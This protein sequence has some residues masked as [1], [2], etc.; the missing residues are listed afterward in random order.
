MTQ[1]TFLNFLHDFFHLAVVDE[2]VHWAFAHV[3]PPGLRQVILPDPAQLAGMTFLPILCVF[4]LMLFFD[5]CF[6]C[7]LHVYSGGQT[8]SYRCFYEFAL[9]FHLFGIVE[10]RHWRR[11]GQLVFQTNQHLL[12]ILF[13]FK[14]L[15]LHFL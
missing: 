7:L 8:G 5:L 9:F 15:P 4:Q 12:T 13:V 10:L 3:S 1:L 2:D 6:A 11:Q 14:M